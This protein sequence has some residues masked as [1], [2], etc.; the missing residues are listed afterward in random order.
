MFPRTFV[1]GIYGVRLWV[2]LTKT[3][4]RLPVLKVFIPI[5]KDGWL[6]VAHDH[7]LLS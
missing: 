6:H 7:E 3:I 5:S 4:G 1:V 2:G